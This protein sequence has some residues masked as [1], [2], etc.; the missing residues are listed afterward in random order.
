MSK[1]CELKRGSIVHIVSDGAWGRYE[2]PATVI[3]IMRDGGPR[4]EFRHNRRKL[5]VWIARDEI[6]PSQPPENER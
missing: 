1:D 5:Q 4:V 6:T 3:E 2:G